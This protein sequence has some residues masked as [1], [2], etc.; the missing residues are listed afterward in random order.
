M[1]LELQVES[2][3]LAPYVHAI[4]LSLGE[5]KWLAQ[6]TQLNADS[7][8]ELVQSFCSVFTLSALRVY[9]FIKINKG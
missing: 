3:Q 1:V 5:D 4:E 9:L 6:S 2:C 7:R 8:V